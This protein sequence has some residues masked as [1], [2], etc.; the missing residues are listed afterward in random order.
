MQKTS[1]PAVPASAKT[2]SALA[3]AEVCLREGE[4]HSLLFLVNNTIDE[5][6]V[7]VPSDW[8]TFA[9]EALKN[10]VLALSGKDSAVL[11]RK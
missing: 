11:L 4:K 5:R 10:G 6:A 7:A 2:A 9:G 8:E 3:G 1:M